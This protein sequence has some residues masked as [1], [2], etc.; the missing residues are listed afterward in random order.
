MAKVTLTFKGHVIQTRCMCR[1]TF[2]VGRSENNDLQ[3]DNPL[4]APLHLRLIENEEGVLAKQVD[5]A[6]PLLVNGKRID[7]QLLKDGDRIGIGKHVIVFAETVRIPKSQE[8]K[9]EEQAAGAADKRPTTGQGQYRKASLQV[10]SGKNIGLVIMLRKPMTRLGTEESGSA[11]ITHRKEGCYL[12]TLA[13]EQTVQ[14]NNVD[15]REESVRLKHGDVLH[16]G[17]NRLKFFCE[18]DL[19]TD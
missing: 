4:V 15:V 9:D 10:M 8:E 12:Y 17:P 16:I 6:F 11:V 5:K 3:I 13:T 1:E 19:E 18:Q 14:I 7:E 2:T